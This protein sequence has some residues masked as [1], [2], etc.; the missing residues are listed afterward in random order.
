MAGKASREGQSLDR[1][2]LCL[3]WFDSPLPDTWKAEQIERLAP[4]ERVRLARIERLLRREQFVV[5]HWML[6]RVLADA[7]YQNAAIEVD[8]DGSVLLN[9]SVPLYVSL[10]HSANVVAVV[11]AGDRV[12]VDIESLKPVRDLRGAAAMLGLPAAGSEDAASILRAWVAA[13]ARQKAGPDAR[14]QV[15]QST[16]DRYQLAV[17]GAANSPLTGGFDGITGN[18]NGIE[19]QWEAV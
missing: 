10:S 2:H 11:I 7:G 4:T 5:G 19:L 16:W 14:E 9:A 17:A 12:G 6:R 18:Y 13:E 15:W 3:S 8:A 1:P